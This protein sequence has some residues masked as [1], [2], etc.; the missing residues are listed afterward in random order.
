MLELLRDHPSALAVA[1]GLHLLLA[2]FLVV[3]IKF[4]NRPVA[5]AFTPVDIV[6]AIAIDG[7]EF[8]EARRQRELEEQRQRQAVIDA[9]RRKEAEARR[10]A[11]LKRQREQQV[12]ERAAAEQQRKLELEQKRQA[13]LER[14]QREEAERQRIAK[15]K[16]EEERRLA[17]ERAAEQRLREQRMAEEEARIAAQLKAEQERLAAIEAERQAEEERRRAAALQ[18]ELA[19]YRDDYVNAITAAIERSWLRP[20]GER[21]G[22]V[23]VILVQQTPGGFIQSV[24]IRKC[25]GSEPFCSSVEK[26]VWRAE[27]LPQPPRP[28]VFERQLEIIFE[29]DNR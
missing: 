24:S 10:Q 20:P 6:E 2:L 7:R 14:K 28:E 25:L 19:R 4:S 11:E 15:Q 9:K 8:D 18:R 3:G 17:E 13:E 23:A 21:R 1:A 16:A 5:P 12:R 27:P 22:Q 26:A 29:P